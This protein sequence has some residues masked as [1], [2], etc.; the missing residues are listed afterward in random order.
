MNN[1]LTLLDNFFNTGTGFLFGPIMLCVFFGTGILMTIVTRGV[2]F[3]KFGVAIRTVFGALRKK[4]DG[5][6]DGQ[7]KPYQA[8]ATALSSCVGNGNVVGVSAA[9]VSGGPG[10]IF[11][12]WIAAITGMATKYAEI[13]LA[14]HFREKDEN[15]IWRGGVMY[16]LTRGMSANW[17]WLAK[18][19]GGLFAVCCVMVSYISCNAVQASSVAGVMGTTFPSV[20]GWVWGVI[21]CILS[22]LCIMGGIQKIG[23]VC[24][25][26]TPIMACI[27]VFF[28]LIILLLNIGAIPAA[29]GLIFKSA[30][31]NQAAWGGITGITIKTAISKG[32]T[33]GIFSNEAGVGG[34]PLV[35]VTSDIEVPAH[36]SLYGI[37]EVFFDTIVICTFTALVILCS[38]VGDL[39]ANGTLDAAQTAVISNTAWKLALGG[40]GDFVVTISLA[41]FCFSTIIGWCT[42]GETSW[43][44]LFG[45]KSLIVFRIIHVAFTFIGCVVSAQVLWDA[46]DFCNGVMCIPNLFSLI[47]FAGLIAKDTKDYIDPMHK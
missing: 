16:I 41:L 38:G 1:F 2:Q 47:I 8:L 40:I 5:K 33:R 32:V 22:A 10:A 27:Y 18:F 34:A 21:I 25:F 4:G 7:L 45:S 36:Q 46:A 17:K 19:L 35:H 43:E 39:V 14:M 13:L 23:K 12:M 26:L 28:G 42:Y 6:G 30:F 29:I 3:R 9:L 24:T 31:S 37:V 11:W 15:G 20:P 44:Y